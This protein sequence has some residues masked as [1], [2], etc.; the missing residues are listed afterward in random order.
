[1][2]T[3]IRFY[4]PTEAAKILKVHKRTILRWIKNGTM[5]AAKFSDGTIRIP[6][7]EIPTY[8]RKEAK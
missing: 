4:T 2:D 6:A 1:M 3:Q 8:A 7:E 5:D